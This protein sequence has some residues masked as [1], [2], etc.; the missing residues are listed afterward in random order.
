MPTYDCS[1]ESCRDAGSV[2]TPSS[3]APTQ[4]F[5]VYIGSNLPHDDSYAAMISK[6]SEGKAVKSMSM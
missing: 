4:A 2:W 5:A 6:Y 3:A 1:T